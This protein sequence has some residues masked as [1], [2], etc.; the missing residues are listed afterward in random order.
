MSFNNWF[1]RQ[2]FGTQQQFEWMET[3]SSMKIPGRLDLEVLLAMED[4]FRTEYGEESTLRYVTSQIIER[5]EEEL[6]VDIIKDW[7]IPDLCVVFKASLESA[8]NSDL[9]VQLAD[10]M[11]QQQKAKGEFFRGLGM[12]LML[13]AFGALFFA[14]FIFGMVPLIDDFSS[15][16]N[17]NGML[18]IIIGAANWIGQYGWVIALLVIALIIPVVLML[19]YWTGETRKAAEDYFGWTG[20][21]LYAYFKC[22]RL[23]GVMGM[24]LRS[25]ISTYDSVD[26][27]K[28]YL[29]PYLR[30][31]LKQFNLLAEHGSSGFDVMDTGLL[32]T[33]SKVRLKV[34]SSNGSTRYEDAMFEITNNAVNDCISQLRSFQTKISVILILLGLSGIGISFMGLLLVLITIGDATL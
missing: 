20:I 15:A 29:P 7:M 26:I 24:L 21:S 34:A 17:R 1:K 23:L 11:G 13:V 33:R 6:L 10:Q 14:G 16:E 12:P 25:G 4:I 28:P 27:I 32:P 9:L 31:H 5:F 2:M 19:P 30:W 3:Y 8:S 22:S 18:P